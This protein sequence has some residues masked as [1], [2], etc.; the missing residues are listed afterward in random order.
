MSGVLE[1]WREEAQS[2]WL[3]GRLAAAEHDDRRREL[4][5]AL[6]AAAAVQA[7]MIVADARAEGVVVPALV[8]STR[9]RLVALLADSFGTGF[10]RPMLASLKIRGLSAWDAPGGTDAVGGKTGVS[11]QTSDNRRAAPTGA[12][13]VGH[14]TPTHMRDIGTRHRSRGAGSTLRAAVFGVNDGL[15]SNTSL[16]LGMAG[17][18]ADPHTVIVAGVAGCLAGAFSM[19]AGEYISMASQRELFE[20]QIAEEK[21]EL[22]RYPEQEAEELAVIYAARGVP[23]EEARR[24]AGHLVRD[25]ERALDTLAREE[26]GVN[27]EDLGSAWGAAV[28]SFLAFAAGAGLPLAICFVAAGANT[29]MLTTISSGVVLFG[30]GALLSLYTGRNAVFGG[31]RMLAVGAAAGAA[32]FAVGK[33]FGVAAG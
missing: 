33:L 5:E 7:G 3:Y 28:S 2:A 12:H 4:F 9:A 24:I 6:G 19:A 21:D 11:A 30:I 8:P 27:P 14:S 26:L 16:I 32:T 17:A 23:M 15:V 1:R 20:H 25:P 18:G 10:V 29:V 22:A 13:V 31:V